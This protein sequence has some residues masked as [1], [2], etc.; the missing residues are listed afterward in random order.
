MVANVRNVRSVRM[1]VGRA[2]RQHSDFD[3]GDTIVAL[4]RLISRHF[5]AKPNRVKDPI[6]I[7][8][9]RVEDRPASENS[10]GHQSRTPSGSPRAR[11]PALKGQGWRRLPASFAGRPATPDHHRRRLLKKRPRCDAKRIGQCDQLGHGDVRVRELDSPDVLDRDPEPLGK[12]LL[13]PAETRPELGD[14]PPDCLF[15]SGRVAGTHGQ[16]VPGTG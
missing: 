16:K 2:P 9:P 1:L 12:L 3:R 14:S 5:A 8:T 11:P 15:D 10:S 13:G 7:E 4:L 6:A